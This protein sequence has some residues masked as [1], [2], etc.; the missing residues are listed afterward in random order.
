[1]PETK[2]IT[3]DYTSRDY[4]AIRSQ[5]VG[6]AKGFIPEWQT[7]GEAGDFGTLLL[8]LF[9]YAS[10]VMNY[11][12][13][14]VG[15][16][17]FLGTAY[18]RQSVMFIADM[19]GYSPIGQQA[20]S[21]PVQLRV[22]WEGT[23][24]LTSTIIIPAGTRLYTAPDS[25]GGI[26]TFT[27]DSQAVFGPDSATGTEVVSGTTYSYSTVNLTATEGNLVG[28]DSPSIIGVSKGHPGAEFRLDDAGVVFRAI[29]VFTDEGGRAVHWNRVARL[30][31]AGPLD[32]AYTTYIDD[33]NFTHIVFGD[34]SSGRIPP[35]NSGIGVQ[36]R[37][38]R[39]AAANSLSANSINN[40]DFDLAY[41]I[42]IALTVHNTASPTGGAD[43]ETSDS[44]RFAAP[45][46]NRI[47]QRAV[48]LDDF[49]A[50]ALQVP[51]IR[52]AVAYGQS[53]STVY[54]R[55]AYGPTAD[56][57]VS[58][59]YIADVERYFADKT[60]VG[61]T[62]YA[63]RPEWND[64]YLNVNVSVNPS[65]NREQ[66]RKNAVAQIQNLFSFDSVDFGQTLAI[67]DLYRT[68]LQVP[69]VDYITINNYQTVSIGLVE[70]D[71]PTAGQLF[72]LI[73]RQIVSSPDSWKVLNSKVTVHTDSTHTYKVGQWVQV[74]NV[75]SRINGLWQISEV[76]DD[77]HFSYLVTTPGV[78]V[79]A[80]AYQ[81]SGSPSATSIYAFTSNGDLV[82]VL[83]NY[84]GG[85]WRD[86]LSYYSATYFDGT[87]WT[88]GT[89]GTNTYA[90]PYG[91]IIIPPVVI[92]PA[93]RVQ[94]VSV[95]VLGSDYAVRL[96]RIR[97]TSSTTV[98]N[99]T[100][101]FVGLVVTAIGGLANS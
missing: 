10:D 80:G 8:E 59:R 38:G 14:R 86:V 87:S 69:G 47:L 24:P 27:L 21:V 50:I 64:I 93:H 35:I 66:V 84:D 77:T 44:I 32:S 60:L 72:G 46:A 75:D 34:G 81:T 51:G 40:I 30:S 82:T 58:Q 88:S 7:V 28:A 73:D 90:Q 95:P 74:N 48:T 13:D 25:Q 12:I 94:D 5:L 101:D 89:P 99:S 76:P 23:D 26:F 31:D 63:E 11:Y 39:G 16:E 79:S 97:P 19:L 22:E 43:V 98:F 36:Y 9:A 52:K 3:L 15:A 2:S 83:K 91:S 68:V 49:K 71:T 37:Y 29:E 4:T 78:T 42:P 20:A 85:S 6:L 67:G 41:P 57:Q 55:A 96:P 54:V 62:V 92:P 45:K 18:R 70:P 33:Q 56:V 1:M 100:D 17:A 61:T 65:Y 53:Y